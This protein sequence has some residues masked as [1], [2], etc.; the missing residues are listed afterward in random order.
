MVTMIGL[1][2]ATA[3]WQISII[4]QRKRNRVLRVALLTLGVLIAG[5]ALFVMI[6]GLPFYQMVGGVN[7]DDFFD[8]HTCDDYLFSGNAM[9]SWILLYPLGLFIF[10][11]S[12]GKKD[13]AK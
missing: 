9:F 4:R 13:N 5:L 6:V 12:G 7:V 1:G 11:M 8:D 10:G 2:I 3:R